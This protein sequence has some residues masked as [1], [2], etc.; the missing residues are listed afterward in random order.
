M[1]VG[2]P[3]Y[4]Y[5][6][7]TDIRVYW[8]AVFS[9]FVFLFADGPP[10][11][12]GVL[13]DADGDP[14]PGEPIT[15]QAGGTQWNTFTDSRGGFRFYETDAAGGEVSVRDRKFAVQFSQPATLTRLKL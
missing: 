10:T 12:S 15:L 2:G 1:T 11:L 3:S 5:A 13:T 8:D 7:P 4:D 9:S 14:L 6:G